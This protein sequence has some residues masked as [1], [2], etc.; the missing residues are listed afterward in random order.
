MKKQGGV[1]KNVR[2]VLGTKLGMTQVFDGDGKIVPVT[3]VAAGPCV[4]TA[5]RSADSDGYATVQLGF[6]EGDPR[7]GSKPVAGVFANARRTPR[8]YRG[9]LRSDDAAQR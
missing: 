1:T 5:V 7:K 2:G 3:V 4:G 6:G 8:R 9:D